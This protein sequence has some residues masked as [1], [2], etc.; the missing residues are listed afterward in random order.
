MV[1]RHYAWRAP[2]AT[3]RGPRG[4][5]EASLGGVA[6]PKA[7][8]AERLAGLA[9]GFG[10]LDACGGCGKCVVCSRLLVNMPY[11]EK[12]KRLGGEERA[13][14][15]TRVTDAA[16]EAKAAAAKRHKRGD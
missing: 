7:G 10:G 8:A 12:A 13:T 5:L 16:A 15:L 1:N 2:E 4:G 14:H 6:G 11:G 9:A 3:V